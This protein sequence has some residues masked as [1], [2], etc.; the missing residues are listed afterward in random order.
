LSATLCRFGLE[1]FGFSRFGG[2]NSLLCSLTGR[3]PSINVV[4]IFGMQ[5]SGCSM[6]RLD[7]K[8]SQVK[9]LRPS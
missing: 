6:K 3:K 5:L 9:L 8:P 4:Y 1:S 7:T 2:L